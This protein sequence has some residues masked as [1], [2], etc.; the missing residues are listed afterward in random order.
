MFHR[1]LLVR[2]GLS[3]AWKGYFEDV[4]EIYRLLYRVW[5]N[6]TVKRSWMG[7]DLDGSS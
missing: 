5:M 3:S 6:E 1:H 7:V 4:V 2:V